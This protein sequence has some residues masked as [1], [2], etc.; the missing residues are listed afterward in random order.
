MRKL[1]RAGSSPAGGGIV[2]KSSWI[3]THWWTTSRTTMK[4]TRKDARSSPVC[5]T[6]VPGELNHSM[7][8]TNW[9]RT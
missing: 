2:A 1:V 9:S 3:E 5:G 7:P 4:S 8:S 6:G